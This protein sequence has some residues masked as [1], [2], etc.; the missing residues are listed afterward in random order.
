MSESRHWPIVGQCSDPR[1]LAVTE[2]TWL[3][4]RYLAGC[5]FRLP[6]CLAVLDPSLRAYPGTRVLRSAEE[7]RAFLLDGASLPL[8]GKENSGLSGLGTFV[9]RDADRDSVLLDGEGAF[10]YDRFFR[11]LLGGVPYV[12]Q[13]VLEN[14][15]VLA[16]HTAALATVRV[17]TIV[18]DEGP[19]HPFFV[20]KLPS[21]GNHSDHF[22]KSGN[23]A[24]GLDP[25]SGRIL[26]A[27]MKHP[28]GVSDRS[29]HP[30][31]SV[32]LIGACVPHWNAVLELARECAPVLAPV[33]YHS[34][35]VAVTPDGPVLVE[36]NVGGSFELV[37]VACDEGFATD[38]VASF[39]AACG[40]APW[41]HSRG[42]A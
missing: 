30:D 11:E 7:L 6:E 21:S 22:W 35:D 42:R 13:S 38:E 4:T 31:T 18:T 14:H 32:P 29:V 41:A 26:R 33:R 2:D 9:I 28:I 17:S 40:V 37:Q 36:A 39:L 5:G 12:L 3:S 23:L 20:L 27:R 19:L 25:S 24:C 34:L 8:F 10:P 1:W 16:R 15:R